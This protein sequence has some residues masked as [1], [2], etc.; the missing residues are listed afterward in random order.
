[1]AYLSKNEPSTEL[2]QFAK[3]VIPVV[4]YYRE[5]IDI[6]ENVWAT[7]EIIHSKSSISQ[8]YIN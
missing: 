1:M 3:K 2:K 6:S 4:W 5:N 7:Y 8:I